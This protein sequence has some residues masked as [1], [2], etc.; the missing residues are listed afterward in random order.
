MSYGFVICVNVQVWGK[1][2]CFSEYNKYESNVIKSKGGVGLL[3]PRRTA[4]VPGHQRAESHRLHDLC[5]HGLLCLHDLR[6]QGD[7]SLGFRE[8]FY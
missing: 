1:K 4:Q 6:T 5:P 3:G 7:S 2:M 8:V